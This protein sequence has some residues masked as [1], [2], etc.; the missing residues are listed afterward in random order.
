MKEAGLP[1]PEYRTEGVFTTVLYK[2]QPTSP[3][4]VIE[5]VIEKTAKTLKGKAKREEDIISLMR[6]SPTI[7]SFAELALALN[8]AER[9]IARDIARLRKEKKI[10]R[11]GGDKG[12]EWVI[13]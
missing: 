1:A 2:K 9:T 7:I 8:V 11:Q 6:S 10:K 13:L 4:N 5:N 3:Q 12:G